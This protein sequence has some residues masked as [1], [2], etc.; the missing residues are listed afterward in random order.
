MRRAA[1]LRLRPRLMITLPVSLAFALD[2]GGELLRPLAAAAIGGLLA[3]VLVALY[4]VPA[5]YS[6]IGTRE[7]VGG[8]LV[9]NAA[10][11]SPVGQGAPRHR[12]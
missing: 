1:E 8:L 3:A 11:R 5:L 9:G 12:A 7:R 2:P 4:L 6:L 10:E